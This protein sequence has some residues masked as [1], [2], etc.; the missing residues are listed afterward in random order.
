MMSGLFAQKK[1]NDT[2][3]KNMFNNKNARYEH[4]QDTSLIYYFLQVH[5]EIS[6]IQKNFAKIH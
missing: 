2:Y 1:F 3:H 5:Y 6:I 4:E